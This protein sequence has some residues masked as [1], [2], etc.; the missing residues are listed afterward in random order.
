MTHLGFITDTV[1]MRYYYPQEKE[2]AL[3][4]LL[5][6]FLEWGKAKVEMPARTWAS[7][8]GKLQAMRRSH[9]DIVN[10]M[11]RAGQHLMGK[12]VATQGW[13]AKVVV[14]GQCLRE[15][16]EGIQRSGHQGGRCGGKDSQDRGDWKKDTARSGGRG[17]SAQGRGCLHTQAG[18]E[19]RDGQGGRV[20][21]GHGGRT[22]R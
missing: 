14:D 9:G 15:L 20:Q 19:D 4:A 22:R 11:S 17:A 6:L 5:D 13:E 3:E 8:L 18:W 7:L 12:A 2:A 10:V 1:K 21:G 16:S